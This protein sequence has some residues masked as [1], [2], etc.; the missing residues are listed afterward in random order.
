MYCVLQ[1]VHCGTYQFVHCKVMHNTKCKTSAVGLS[2]IWSPSF[3][4]HLLLQ[5][6]RKCTFVATGRRKEILTMIT[7][8]F[9]IAECSRR[10]LK[11]RWVSPLPHAGS[12]KVKM[13]WGIW[14]PTSPPSERRSEDSSCSWPSLKL[15]V[16]ALVN[17]MWFTYLNC[18]WNKG[19]LFFSKEAINGWKGF[20]T[21]KQGRN[22]SQNV[23]NWDVWNCRAE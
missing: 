19:W 9:G 7:L 21:C 10:S 20:V 11:S 23:E 12:L 13:R 17:K 18:K 22:G 1:S 3:Y 15:T 6:W 14:Q 4:S 8:L 16:S 5:R 2:G